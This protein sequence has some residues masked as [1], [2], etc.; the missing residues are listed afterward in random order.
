MYFQS[1][2]SALSFYITTPAGNMYRIYPDKPKELVNV[3]KS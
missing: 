2:E 3:F 1:F